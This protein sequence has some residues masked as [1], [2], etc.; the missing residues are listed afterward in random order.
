MALTINLG[1]TAD[2]TGTVDVITATY[3][4]APTLVDNKVLFLQTT[5]TNTGAVTFN[6]NGV[7]AK[8]VVIEGVALTAGQMP[9]FAILAYDLAN[10]R[11]ELLN[12][13]SGAGGGETLAQTLALGNSTDAYDIVITNGQK[14]KSS[15]AN[16]SFLQFLNG[17]EVVL[18]TDGGSYTKA[19]LYLSQSQ[20][21]LTALGYG[22]V[23]NASYI[24]LQHNSLVRLDA[25][26]VEVTQQT[27]S[28]ILS[29]DASKNITAL[30]TATYPSLTELSYIKG[31]TSAIQTQLNAKVY[32]LI[33]GCSNSSPADST[34]YYIGGH[35]ATTILTSAANTVALAVPVS[36][37]IISS[38]VYMVG[39]NGTNENTTFEV[40]VNDTTSATITSAASLAAIASTGAI[41]SNYAMSQAVTAGDWLHLRM[42]CPAWAT[43]PTG[44]RIWFS[45]AIRS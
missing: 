37:T 21:E 33:G 16:K 45:I 43:N 40:R 19:Y 13:I 6:P 8:A 14:V 41:A 9:K 1:L 28:R 7:G 10:T 32:T 26:S 15:T 18:E 20:A 4:P 29:T 31:L 5:G 38:V 22:V 39:A 12:P 2:A 35:P 11:W 17:N 23:A 44:V 27:A 30:D 42:I 25:P 36:G 34:T 3:S 24:R